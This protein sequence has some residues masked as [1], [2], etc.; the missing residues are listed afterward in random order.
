MYYCKSTKKTTIKKMSEQ[1][2]QELTI[3]VFSYGGW[4]RSEL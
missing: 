3:A 1:L 2:E 4:K